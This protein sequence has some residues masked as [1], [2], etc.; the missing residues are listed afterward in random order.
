MTPLSARAVA[1]FLASQD[2]PASG[3]CPNEPVVAIELEYKEHPHQRKRAMSSDAG[4]STYLRTETHSHHY[5]SSSAPLNHIRGYSEN[6]HPGTGEQMSDGPINRNSETID[7][8][9]ET[10]SGSATKSKEPKGKD[11]KSFT[12]NL[13]DTLAMRMLEW[14]PLRSPGNTSNKSNVTIIAATTKASVKTSH[15]CNNSRRSQEDSE[16]KKVKRTRSSSQPLATRTVVKSLDGVEE[17]RETLKKRPVRLPLEVHSADNIGD[18][19]QELHEISPEHTSLQMLSLKTPSHDHQSISPLPSPPVLKNRREKHSPMSNGW[20]S[21]LGKKRD[22]RVSWDGSKL[23]KGMEDSLEL[24]N[25]QP[26]S[27]ISDFIGSGSEDAAEHASETNRKNAKHP[28][29]WTTVSQTLTYVDAAVADGINAMICEGIF[30][31]EASRRRWEMARKMSHLT[32]YLSGNSKLKKLHDL[33][34]QSIFY[35]FGYPESMLLSFIAESDRNQEKDSPTPNTDLNLACYTFRLFYQMKLSTNVGQ[36]IWQGLEDLF[37]P[38]PTL[39]HTPRPRKQSSHRSSTT[40]GSLKKSIV[41]FNGKTFISDIDAAHIILISFAALTAM[42]PTMRQKKWMALSRARARGNA[43]PDQARDEKWD[44]TSTNDDYSIGDLT[45]EAYDV[46][47]DE[48][49]LRLL[50]RLVRAISSR[51]TAFEILRLRSK[52]T[53]SKDLNQTTVKRPHVLDLVLKKIATG[54]PIQEIEDESSLSSQYIL[55]QRMP[56]RLV[57]WIRTCLLKEWNGTPLATRGSIF[58]SAVLVLNAFHEHRKAL[59]L[60]AEIFYTPRLSQRL[61]PMQMPG[62]W[63]A[64]EL[65]NDNVHLLDYSFLLPPSDVVVYFRSINFAVMTKAYEA[66]IVMDRLIRQMRF[67][68]HEIENPPDRIR[69]R[70]KVATRP[71]LVLEVSRETPLEDTLNQLWKRE[72]R[73]MLRPMKVRIGKELNEEGIDQGGVQQELFRLILAEVLNP[74]YGMFTVD[75]RTRMS[76]FQPCSLESPSKFEMVG[77]LFSLALYNGLTLPITFPLALYRKLLGLRVKTID[78]IEDGWPELAKGLDDLQNWTDGD[79]GDVFLRTYDFSFDAFGTPINVDMTKIGRDDPWPPQQ[80]FKGKGKS[81]TDP[82]I[83]GLTN[84][85]SHQIYSSTTPTSFRSSRS[86]TALQDTSSPLVTNANRT[87]YIK[88]YIYWLTTKSIAPQF[89]AFLRG[90]HVCIDPK[91]LS[92][93]TPEALRCVLEGSQYIDIEALEKATKYDDQSFGGFGAE[94]PYT[95][96]SQPVRWFWEVVRSWDMSRKRKLLEFVTASD[97]V[98]VTGTGTI[99]FSIIRNGSGDRVCV[100]TLLEV[101][102]LL[103]L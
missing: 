73:E 11:P 99:S 54:M 85:E 103:S 27:D 31:K 6:G 29:S 45:L 19:P 21:D 95:K 42:L 37:V 60:D 14:V 55:L 28:P 44:Y 62:E 96:D 57:E 56:L 51:L 92:I 75:E 64:M 47:E 22:R 76:W 88:D 81:K 12:Q 1:T 61:D 72:K 63:L 77:L 49:N 70:L 65:N 58:G 17:R 30:E 90:F 68:E 43:L 94:R 52:K 67:T 41:V 80:S 7:P 2:N 91:A 39:I 34:E 9:Q 59:G 98:P 35:I 40:K 87:Q 79:V 100:P 71:F 101:S 53:S 38:P 26:A 102:T 20:I 3:L 50:Y 97:R 23:L 82:T 16:R 18:S 86:T 25:V 33:L 13:F 8:S 84:L 78:H 74:E 48:M 15:E 69:E 93:F 24:D 32:T 83:P 10:L 66:T 46:L 36:A 5:R 89:T 4:M